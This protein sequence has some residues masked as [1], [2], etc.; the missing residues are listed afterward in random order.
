MS[1]KKVLNVVDK[2]INGYMDKVP[3]IQ[4]QIYKEILTLTKDLKLDNRGNI[5]NTIDNYKILANLR[6]RL[7]KVIFT[8]DYQKA[9]QEL[10]NSYDEINSTIK[11]YIASF[12][13]SP[14]STTLD[15]LKIIRTQSIERTLLYLG[16][17][18]ININV[19][20]KVQEI[21][22]SNITTGG[23]YASYVNQLSEFV[24]GSENN[25]GS[26]EKYAN[27]IVVDGINTYSRTYTNAIVEDLGLE[28]FQYTGSLLTT[29]RE[30]CEHMVKKRW[31]HK[32]ELSTILN[33]NIDGVEI[34]SSKIPCSKNKLP[35]GMKK[36]TTTTNLLDLAGGWNCGHRFIPVDEIIIPDAIKMTVYNSQSYKE[37]T[38]LNGIKPKGLFTKQ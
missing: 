25:L 1:I 9:T 12:A 14:S 17:S 13:T 31:V 3:G 34:C 2:S 23:S 21:L 15:V 28:W 26:F 30:W 22:Q 8:K 33:D 24:V 5:K 4:K 18:G 35:R 38:K 32:S 11:D 20:G 6:S 19:I 16:E 36:E 29:S 7:E 37:W 10:I 27:T